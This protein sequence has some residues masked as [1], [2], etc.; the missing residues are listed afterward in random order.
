MW[1]LTTLGQIKHS[2]IDHFSTVSVFCRLV[3]RTSYSMK[4]F[5]RISQIKYEERN[6]IQRNIGAGAN[7]AFAH[8]HNN[9]SRIGTGGVSIRN[10]PP[11]VFFFSRLFHCMISIPPQKFRLESRSTPYRLLNQLLMVGDEDGASR[12]EARNIGPG[13]VKEGRPRGGETR[14]TTWP[15]SIIKWLLPLSDGKE[16]SFL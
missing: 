1:T 15:D 5:V 12:G 14:E 7:E 11:L 13:S 2:N 6:S 8:W 9:S 16:I 4:S 10:W 3:L